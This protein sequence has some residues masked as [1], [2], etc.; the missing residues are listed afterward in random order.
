V[1]KQNTNVL[2]CR[3]ASKSSRYRDV[4]AIFGVAEQETAI[5]W[6]IVLMVRRCDPLA[7]VLTAAVSSQR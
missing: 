5:R 4:A 6:L 7:L 2:A 1:D 3:M